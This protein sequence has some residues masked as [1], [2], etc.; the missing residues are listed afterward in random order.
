[1]FKKNKCCNSKLMEVARIVAKNYSHAWQG[2]YNEL[3]YI[4]YET[5]LTKNEYVQGHLDAWY[6]LQ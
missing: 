6:C 5:K 3:G 1:M 2:T 4:E